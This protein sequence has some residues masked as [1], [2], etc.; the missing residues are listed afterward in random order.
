MKILVSEIPEEGLDIHEEENIG[1]E[2]GGVAEKATLSL[3][4]EKIDAEVRLKGTIEADMSL[5]C[6]RCLKPFSAD[7]S[8]P[9]DLVFVPAEEADRAEGHELASDE[10]N[11]GFYRGGE[12]D[13]TGISGEQVLLNTPMKPL[14]SES[15][16][17]ICPVCGTDLNEK[18]C[19]CS[20]KTGDERMQVLKKFFERRKE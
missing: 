1:A 14:C 7:I 20:P 13:L 12:I 15:C 6:S 18:T 5:Q 11:T 9:V 8:V 2:T 4:V 17:G 19:D 3:R 10:L 16:K